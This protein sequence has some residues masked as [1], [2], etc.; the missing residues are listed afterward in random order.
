MKSIL[1]IFSLFIVLQSSAQILPV[2]GGEINV[3]IDTASS[4]N[5][6]IK[7][8]EGD[9]KFV[10]TNKAY[11]IGYTADMFSIAA[12]KEAAI[13][14][15][16]DF[17]DKSTNY[18]AKVGALCALHLIGIN[19]NIAGRDY[20]IFSNEKARRALLYLLKYDDLQPMIIGLL[21]RDANLID[22]P[23]LFKAMEGSNSD[24]WAL[25]NFLTQF[26]INA[27]IAQ[28]I[29]E[30]FNEHITI[31]KKSQPYS[32]AD[33]INELSLIV[34]KIGRA[35]FKRIEL[36]TL[37]LNANLWGQCMHGLIN[38]FAPLGAIKLGV[39]DFLYDITEIRY[40]EIGSKL[41]Y[42]VE[43]DKI[44]I[45]TQNTAKLR[46]LKFWHEMPL[47]KKDKFR[48]FKRIEFGSLRNNRFVED[49][50]K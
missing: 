39:R 45:C 27:P 16:V 22:V 11:W 15:L 31:I 32:K 13:Q 10:E 42:Y 30:K 49:G 12:K 33:M 36:D 20:E 9:W 44:Y 1:L 43:D 5:E 17:V 29:P 46:L 34:S 21:N 40:T 2:E 24:C 48:Y 4:L 14:I 41:Q 26:S 19:S 28:Y 38:N 18:H 37:L 47:A 25:N 35:G 50:G 7:R 6:L 23:E 8:L 3:K